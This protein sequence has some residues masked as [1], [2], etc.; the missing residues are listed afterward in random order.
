LRPP[1]PRG[2][3]ALAVRSTGGV[4]GHIFRVGGEYAYF[5]GAFNGPTATFTDRSLERLK[6]RIVASRPVT[7]RTSSV[8]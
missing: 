6:K 2:V 8:S 5:A 4:I 7:P 1:P 3:W